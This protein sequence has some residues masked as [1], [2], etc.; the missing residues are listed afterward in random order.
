MKQDTFFRKRRVSYSQDNYPSVFWP[1]HPAS[2]EKR[3]MVYIHRIIAYEKWGDSIF[4]KHVHHKDGDP[5]NWSEDNLKLVSLK[6]HALIHHWGDLDSCGWDRE[7][8]YCGNIINIRSSSRNKQK[9]V[10]CNKLCMEKIPKAKKIDW[11]S[12]DEVILLVQNTNFS[13]AGRKLGVSDN[14]IRKFLTRNGVDYKSI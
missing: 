3:G 2:S 12:V 11:P 9:R 8:S 1:E 14:A 13:A 6:E 5:T 4:G 10:F 7:C